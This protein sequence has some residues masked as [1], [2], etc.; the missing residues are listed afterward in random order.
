M[1]GLFEVLPAKTRRADT[2][3]SRKKPGEIGSIIEAQAK[4]YFTNIQR[5]MY[6][7]A[8]GAKNLLIMNATASALAR[9]ASHRLAQIPRRDVQLRGITRRAARK[10]L[11]PVEQ[12][13]KQEGQIDL[14]TRTGAVTQKLPHNFGNHTYGS[15][16][17]ET[18]N[19]S[20]IVPHRKT[21]GLISFG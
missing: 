20:G 5:S 11:L 9:H 16:G 1:F 7:H 10:K 3:H 21:D 8:P 13:A 18:D 2:R 6:Q 14:T 4:G 17:Q 12:F 19:R 15:P